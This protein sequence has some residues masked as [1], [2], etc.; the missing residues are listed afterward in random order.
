MNVPRVVIFDLGKV[1]LDFDYGI[2]ARRIAARGNVAP[3]QVQKFLDHSP[4]LYRF[5]TGLM[6]NDQFFAEVCAA[7]QFSG[8]QSEFSDFFADIFTPIPPM[9]E[10]QAR[11]RAGGIPTHIFSNTNELAIMHIRRNFPFFAN[12]DGYM[13]S[14][15]RGVM[16]PDPKAYAIVERM[17]GRRGA[18]ILYLDDRAE[19]VTAGAARGWQVILQESPE[20]TV[21]A[22][23]TLGLLESGG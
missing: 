9:V 21:R 14:Y 1:L 20:K 2:A 12:F 3:E 7:T 8:T 11:L 4:L 18:D 19:N 22:I 6:T 5:E 13:L 16:K 17:T 23:R 10:L 15:E